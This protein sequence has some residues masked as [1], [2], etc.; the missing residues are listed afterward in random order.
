MM[1]VRRYKLPEQVDPVLP[2]E[3][4]TKNYVD[5]QVGG[6]QVYSYAFRGTVLNG[7]TRY[8]PPVGS[9][10]VGNVESERRYYVNRAQT[11]KSFAVY[12]SALSGGNKTYSVFKNGIITTLTV[13]AVAVGLATIVSDV[14]LVAG[15]SIS[16]ESTGAGSGQHDSTEVAYTV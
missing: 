16:I 9:A 2:Q 12:V 7:S 6:T 5:S 3:V 1:K 10:I 8:F 15:D 4:A 13:T 14:S 11:L